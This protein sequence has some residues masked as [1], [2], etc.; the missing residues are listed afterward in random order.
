MGG[1]AMSSSSSAHN[2]VLRVLI[3]GGVSD[4]FAEVKPRFERANGHRLDIFSGPMPE[5]I[6]EITSGRP[7]D[8]AATPSDV[9]KDAS[10]RAHFDP[11]TFVDIARVGFGVAVRTGAAKPDL[12]S[13]EAFKQAMLNAATITFLPASATGAQVLRVFERLGIA[14]AMKKK[15]VVQT[16]PAKIAQAVADGDAELAVFLTN[17]LNAPGVELAG[18]FPPELQQDFV[19][20]AALN[21]NPNEPDAARAL[22]GYLRSPEVTEIIKAK[23][24]RP[25]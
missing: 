20:T 9:M 17:V 4:V 19:F 5:L 18:P 25:G 22:L 13:T 23:G 16:A 8:L 24:M 2:A 14:E 12:G 1:T 6:K 15:T 21:V 3:G 7:F 11:A 10:A